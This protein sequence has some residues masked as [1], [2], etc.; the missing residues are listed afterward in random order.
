MKRWHSLMTLVLVAFTLCGCIPRRLFWSP[1]GQHAAIIAED[2]LRLCDAAGK[3]TD[4]VAKDVELVAWLPDSRRFIAECSTKAATWAEAAMALSPERR[5]A[6]IKLADPLRKEAL[7]YSGDWDKFK[8]KV[9]AEMSD[10]ELAA[11]L[12]YV[13]DHHQQG[14]PEKLGEKW[15]DI[16]KATAEV[17][18]LQVYE[19]SNAGAAPGQVLTRTLDSIGELRLSPDG[20]ALACVQ[21]AT[22][23]D[24]SDVYRLSVL[25]VS[26][27]VLRTVLE[28]VAVFPDWTTDG[29]SLVYTTT[30]KGPAEGKDSLALGTIA[31]R[32]VRDESGEL[33]EEFA[34]PE[35]L[36]GI[37]F[38]P[39]MKIR[40]L[41]DGRILFS[42][43][44]VT[45]P[46]TSQDMPQRA[47]LFSIEPGKRP[48]VARAIPRDA[49][50][51]LPDGLAAGYFEVSPDA[52]RIAVA[53]TGH[54][55]VSVLTLATGAVEAVVNQP[56]TELKS[57]P[58]WRTSQELSL[59]VPPKSKW[60]SP[61]RYEVVLWS[62]PDKARCLSCDWPDIFSKKETPATGP[63]TAPSDA[64][65]KN[66]R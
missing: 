11:L 35:D 47:S 36:V 65:G 16:E 59:F 12:L 37:V 33:L 62:A 45:L 63:A 5:D 6:L 57:I 31:K 1:D 48:T 15:K 3:L 64:A 8:P 26:G 21:K 17:H 66:E 29:R 19:L 44:E 40:C 18:A 41:P 42:A 51:S 4:V 28:P 23:G 46:S 39:Q 49:E 38:G 22:G 52:T 54:G 32:A 50:A 43:M 34:A 10:G 53:A 60:G 2:G 14:L 30:R 7:A 20:R 25:P 55:D 61:D 9:A 27:G 13:R 24:N 56:D 58:A